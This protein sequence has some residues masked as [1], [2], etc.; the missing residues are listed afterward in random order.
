MEHNL[1]SKNK[2]QLVHLSRMKCE[3]DLYIDSIN[4]ALRLEHFLVQV[5]DTIDTTG[6]NRSLET[7]AFSGQDSP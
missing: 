6:L 7:R 1:V 3:D 4:R 5:V 2:N